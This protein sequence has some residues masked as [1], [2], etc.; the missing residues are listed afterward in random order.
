MSLLGV[1]EWRASQSR[2]SHHPTTNILARLSIPYIASLVPLYYRLYKPLRTDQ[3]PALHA[4]LRVGDPRKSELF[5]ERQT[6]A[7][8]YFL[9]IT[10]TRRPGGTYS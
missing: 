9:Y 3:Y 4:G 5:P 10:Q 6:I 1:N 2:L 8:F 7:F